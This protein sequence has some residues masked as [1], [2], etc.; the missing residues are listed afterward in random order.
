MTLRF[1]MVLL[2][3]GSPALDVLADGPADNQVEKIRPVPPPGIEVP[4]QVRESLTAALEPLK[5][6]I[7]ELSLS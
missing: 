4:A 7:E 1:L 2:L 3:L 5:K 6:S